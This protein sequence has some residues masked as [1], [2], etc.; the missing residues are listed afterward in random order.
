MDH[1]SPQQR[2]QLMSRIRGKDTKPEMTL[3]RALHA[4]GYRYRVHQRGLPGQPDIVFARRKKVI[5]VHGCFWHWHDETSCS[6]AKLPKSRTEFWEAKFLRNRQRDQRQARE[7]EALG[8]SA[9]I[10]WECQLASSHLKDTLAKV[11]K[12][13]GEPSLA[14]PKRGQTGVRTPARLAPSKGS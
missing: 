7:M 5:W 11:E 12:F 14:K 6:I 2:S 10:V 3:R 13:L 9:M 4:L 8:W 1:I